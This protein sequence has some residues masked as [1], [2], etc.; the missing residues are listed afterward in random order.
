M[1]VVSLL[2]RMARMVVVRASEPPTFLTIAVMVIRSKVVGLAGEC[3]RLE[4]IRS[5]GAA[6][7]MICVVATLLPSFFSVTRFVTSAVA[8]TI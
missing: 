8:V 2:R 1:G 7:T 6:V 5:G 3:V 4:T